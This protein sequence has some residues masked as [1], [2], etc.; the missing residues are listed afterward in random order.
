MAVTPL[1]KPIQNKKGILY[2]FQSSIEDI[3]LNLTN[4]PNGVRYSKFALIRLP[5]IGTPD[6]LATDNK[7]QFFA[8]GETPII[9]GLNSD[10]N[11]NLAES[12]QNYALNLE[13][14]LVSQD[15]YNFEN[16]LT[17]AERVFF[18]WVKELGGIRFRD[19]NNLQKNLNTLGSEKRFVEPD[20]STST[21]KRVVQYVA[22][23]DV[24]NSIRSAD[25]AY[26]EIFIHVPT[27]VG[28]TPYVLFKSIKDEN[29]FPNQTITNNPPDP[30]DIEYL[31]GR[32]YNEIN[33]FG[34]S[35]KAFYDR[36]DGSVTTDITNDPTNPGSLLP[37]NWYTELTNNSYFTDDYNSTGEFNVAADQLIR[38]QFGSTSVEYVRNTLDG[39]CI[40]FD[41]DNYRL[42]AENQEIKAFTQLN[43]YVNNKNFE[44][45]AVLIY[46]DVFDPNNLDENG[47]PIDPVTNLY[48][49]LFLDKVEQKGLE[50]IIPPIT[51]YMP[52]PL[53]GTNGNAFSHKPNL[54]LDTSVENVLVE[55]SINDY[56]T[57]SM[58]LFLD[59][60][61]QFK[62]LQVMYND[63]LLELNALQTE[64]NNLK[65]LLINQED[66]N[67]LA[68]RITNLE[69]SVASSQALFN[70]TQSVVNMIENVND[71]VNGIISG[72]TSI[73][74]SYN[75]DVIKAGPGI[76]LDKSIPN[77]L[78]ISNSTQEYNI[79]NT[80]ITN[81]F[82]NNNVR[83]G[84]FS[85]YV[86]HENAGLPI[87]LTK[88]LELFI[89]DT[90]I[91]WSKGQSLQLVIH[92][93]ID[94]GIYNLKIYTDALNKLGLGEFG[95]NIV[96]LNDADFASDDTPIFQIT[97]INSDTLEFKVDKIR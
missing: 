37:G 32:R 46:Y 83:L 75:L 18:K 19:A 9:E 76:L 57:F 43:D 22:D 17:V 97:C 21:Y 54:K 72:N 93:A 41:L 28:T 84:R 55:K 38:K 29:Y 10:N 48:G 23:I 3:Q 81:I 96:N 59:V 52:D 14:L 95:K 56:S 50:F 86:R 77:R 71:R 20:D 16:K 89:N 47:N 66:L 87:T 27:N 51:K 13:A 82:T 67:E 90:D 25:N 78:K 53:N 8:P 58:D 94:L 74:V 60:L 26:T 5:E 64:V 65:D 63:K 68:I 80:S 40:D 11:I 36:D 31:K 24:V 15:S 30:L 69:T 85:N 2:N 88:D 45:N 49:I 44:Y 79:E 70:N 61:T 92:D 62:Q 6:T 42:A 73:Q 91:A 34:L 1:I 39:V 33:P 4:N 35:L 12:F 7:V